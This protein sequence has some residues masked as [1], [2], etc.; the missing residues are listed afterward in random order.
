MREFERDKWGRLLERVLQS[1][2]G[3]DVK[4][5]DEWFHNGL[6]SL[7]LDQGE[8]VLR[9]PV[10][11]YRSYVAL[12]RET[13]VAHAV[14]ATALVELGAGYGSVLL[15]V[16]ADP[17][18]ARCQLTAAEL[19]PSGRR[20]TKLVAAA[21]GMLVEAVEC[22]LEA[23]SIMQLTP[24]PGSI[25][26]TSFALMYLNRLPSVFFERVASW[27]PSM[28]IHVEPCTEHSDT[29]T[30]LGLLQRRYAEVNGYNLT[31]ASDICAAQA[32]GIVEVTL[33]EP[34]WVGT[35]PLLPGSLIMWRPVHRASG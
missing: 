27:R 23:E 24:A 28:V 2:T 18:L 9:D 7:V 16:A 31:I 35:N 3:V 15:G 29:Q 10:A 13:I 19:T 34:N 26:F 33:S 11:A 14:G 17:A 8:L 25:I 20:L 1:P 30:I 12:L 5:L 22:D 6:P 32:Q 21:T 4:E